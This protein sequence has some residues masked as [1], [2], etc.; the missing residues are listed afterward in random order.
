MV[1]V[2]LDF[3]CAE[4]CYG[5]Y[6][7]WERWVVTG[8]S[9][10]HSELLFFKFNIIMFSIKLVVPQILYHPEITMIFTHLSKRS[11]ENDS[12][13]IILRMCS[14]T[15]SLGEVSKGYLP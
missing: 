11:L 12:N 9:F 14:Q 1:K 8:L 15:V 3:N 7:I 2:L 4:I 6:T 5:F 10:K 13:C